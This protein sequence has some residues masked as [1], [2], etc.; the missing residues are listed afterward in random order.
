MLSVKSC[1]LI[2]MLSCLLFVWHGG[3]Y[4]R[5]LNIKACNFNSQIEYPINK[6]IYPE[7]PVPCIYPVH[8]Q[9]SVK[10][11]STAYVGP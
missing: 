9:V 7:S 3:D 4:F 11:K 2:Y 5:K 10:S 6:Y 1:P 8:Y